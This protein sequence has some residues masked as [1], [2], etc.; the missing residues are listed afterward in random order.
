M[1][2]CL[3]SELAGCSQDTLAQLPSQRSMRQTVA[4]A[5]RAL[6]PPLPKTL[7]EI[8][9]NSLLVDFPSWYHINFSLMVK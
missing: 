8:T 7:A 2:K 3:D 4:R 5:R 6:L 9:V 1:N